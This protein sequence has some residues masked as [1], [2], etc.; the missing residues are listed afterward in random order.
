M[1][2]IRRTPVAVWVKGNNVHRMLEGIELMLSHGWYK[3]AITWVQLL[4]S[5]FSYT[6]PAPGNDDAK[7]KTRMM[8]RGLY[9]VGRKMEQI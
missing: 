9:R 2:L 4:R 6:F 3:K 7:P 1:H 5:S 8:M